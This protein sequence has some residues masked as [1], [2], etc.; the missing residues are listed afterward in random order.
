MQLP[1]NCG[2]NAERTARRQ[3]ADVMLTLYFHGGIQSGGM[4]GLRTLRALR[5]LL[6]ISRGRRGTNH[7]TRLV[8]DIHLQ[9]F[10][11]RECDWAARIGAS[12]LAVR[13]AWRRFEKRVQ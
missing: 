10:R 12:R 3:P 7:Y 1:L 8:D 9:P 4:M 5:A 11:D 6:R 13:R 2:L